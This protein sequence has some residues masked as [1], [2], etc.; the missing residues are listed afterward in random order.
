MSPVPDS[1]TPVAHFTI[2]RGGL[3]DGT[4]TLL[5]PY[6]SEKGIG[7]MI[8]AEIRE[9]EGLCSTCNNA[10]TCFH[11]A[12]RGPALFCELFDSYV[13]PTLRMRDEGASLSARSSMTPVAQEQ[14]GVKLG[15]LCMNCE[16]RRTCTLPKL[17]GGV[18]HC[19]EYR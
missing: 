16:N 7:D 15:G 17:A 9:T 11:R 8:M 10:P 5:S 4:D 2:G 19:E 18:W 14:D 12:R 1:G 6:A 3:S 13:P